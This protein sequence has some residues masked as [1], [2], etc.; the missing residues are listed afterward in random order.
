MAWSG[1]RD[2]LTA[3]PAMPLSARAEPTSCG[4]Q[5]RRVE[6]GGFNT[7]TPAETADGLSSGTNFLPGQQQQVVDSFVDGSLARPEVRRVGN[8]WALELER[9]GFN[10]MWIPI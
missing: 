8:P 10:I 4:Q 7:G 1:E 3:I 2:R 9:R 5:Q 6:G